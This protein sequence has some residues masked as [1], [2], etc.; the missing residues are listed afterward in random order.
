MK[1]GVRGKSTVTTGAAGK[2]AATDAVPQGAG[3]DEGS[4]KKSGKAE[5][6]WVVGRA[7]DGIEERLT[8]KQERLRVREIGVIE[9]SSAVI[10]TLDGSLEA[11]EDD[12]F[13]EWLTAQESLNSAPAG[14]EKANATNSGEIVDEPGSAR[15]ERE[16]VTKLL[17]EAAARLDDL[18][19]AKE[20]SLFG[21]K[22]EPSA[23]A[24]EEAKGSG[25]NAGGGAPEG[26][27]LASSPPV[28]PEEKLYQA[29]L[30]LHRAMLSRCLSILSECLRK[31]HLK[32]GINVE[33]I[34]NAARSAYLAGPHERLGA[35]FPLFDTHGDGH[36]DSD[37][38]ERV[39]DAAVLSVTWAAERCYGVAARQVLDKKSAKVMPKTMKYALMDA[40]QV[41]LK[42]RCA[43][44]WAENRKQVGPDEWRVSW[45]QFA[46][47]RRLNYPEY[48]S[49]AA[50][51]MS[52]YSRQRS[53]WHEQRKSSRIT[54]VYGTVLFFGVLAVDY[55]LTF[56]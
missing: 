32:P 28:S 4:E 48:D 1:G 7:M 8:A 14:E 3:G 34:A 29:K 26:E 53:E 30:V 6:L 17:S 25:P 37:G 49:T 39:V 55:L 42:R 38:V 56:V 23:T 54:N 5:E 44:A 21:E 33:Q 11:R 19:A 51:Y 24:G 52:D 27:V 12:E 22:E 9:R 47:S 20:E 41:P 10:S 35:V 31:E 2:A 13:L 43:F 15:W 45:E 40:L 46:P 16:R 50:K 18:V 36:L